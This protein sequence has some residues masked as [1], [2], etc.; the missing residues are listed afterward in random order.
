MRWDGFRELKWDGVERSVLAAILCCV[1]IASIWSSSFD[2]LA[3]L[4][5]ATPIVSGVASYPGRSTVAQLMGA[6]LFLFVAMQCVEATYAD[7][8]K[9]LYQVVFAKF[10]PFDDDRLRWSRFEINLLITAAATAI[11]GIASLA[12]RAAIWGFKYTKVKFS[13]DTSGS[14]NPTPSA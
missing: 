14:R 11:A 10:N 13:A 8:W 7:S 12:A 3:I 6:F 5:A 9:A 1:I 4:V 2:R